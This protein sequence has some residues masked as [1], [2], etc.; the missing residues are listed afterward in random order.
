MRRLYYQWRVW[1]ICTTLSNWTRTSGASSFV[2]R[3]SNSWFWHAFQPSKWFLRD[4]VVG[5]LSSSV[6]H[7]HLLLST[8]PATRNFKASV[9]QILSSIR[10]KPAPFSFS[11][12]LGIT[13]IHWIDNE[14][15]CCYFCF[16]FG[17]SHCLCASGVCSQQ[18]FDQEFIGNA[19]G[20][21]YPL[22][23]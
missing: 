19:D 22:I 10:K 18:E 5:G 2:R 7:H 17:I 9:R 3:R 11:K 12:P 15:H 23:T 8:Q 21:S 1:I 13:T 4:V 14:V 6:N 16:A 20:V